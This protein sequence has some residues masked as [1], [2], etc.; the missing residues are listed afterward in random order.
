MGFLRTALGKIP[1][2]FTNDIPGL[3][4]LLLLVQ[5][6]FLNPGVA[7]LWL[8]TGISSE[9]CIDL[10]LHQELAASFQIDDEGRDLRRRV[11]WCAWEME[12]A[13][14]A[15]FLRPLRILNK[16]V[17]AK[18]PS[19][20]SSQY[21]SSA[22]QNQNDSVCTH[23][24]LHREIEA[25]ILSVLHQNEPLP[26]PFSTLEEWMAQSEQDIYDW[27][28]RIEQ[29][30]VSKQDGPE[31]AQWDEMNIY[32]K[33]GTN[34]L[35]VLLYRLSTRE[36]FPSKEHW[37]KAFSA[38]VGVA[39]G[40]TQ[41]ANTEY[42]YI[43][44]VF[45]P[46]HHTFSAAMTFIQALSKCMPEVS[47]TYCLEEVEEFTLRFSRFF[48]MISERWHAASRC[49]REYNQLLENVMKDY[50]SFLL[51]DAT[52]QFASSTPTESFNSLYE[53]MD[54]WRILRPGA[55]DTL[56]TSTD[57]FPYIPYDWDA[58][59]ELGMNTLSSD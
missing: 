48:L 53:S 54:P 13:V 43:K 56:N 16:H 58:E 35:L 11:F 41:Q 50:R 59:F 26:P 9:A 19:Y 1:H 18:F 44:Y 36:R 52:H 46:C 3:Q 22:S 39:T 34:V 38:A 17:T 15:A 2:V 20:F 14:S 33:T 25:R 4:A 47:S 31:R 55:N 8:L 45:H 27:L 30:V 57:P 29:I 23:I 12:V 6:I 28:H 40:Y 42:G 32:A 37:M 10:G 51:E 24:W 49:L 5:Y 21:S 7:D